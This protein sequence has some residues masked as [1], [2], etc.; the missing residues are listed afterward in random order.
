MLPF[1]ASKNP[2]PHRRCA[3]ALGSCPSESSSSKGLSYKFRGSGSPSPSC[4]KF[5]IVSWK[6]VKEGNQLS[7]RLGKNSPPLL[8][9]HAK[10][11]WPAL[12]CALTAPQP[13]QPRA[14]QKAAGWPQLSK[15]RAAIPLGLQLLPT[16]RQPCSSL[17]ALR[18]RVGRVGQQEGAHA[19]R[20]GGL[21][22]S[23]ESG[24]S[25]TVAQLRG[26]GLTESPAPTPP[27]HVP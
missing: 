8:G 17:G 12:S 5:T 19:A 24:S 13:G 22:R 11:G 3:Q 20:P 4:S 7:L 6:G 10:A 14:S 16:R 26:R 18:P 9:R 25:L 1:P 27:G 2:L 23:R 15:P 21:G